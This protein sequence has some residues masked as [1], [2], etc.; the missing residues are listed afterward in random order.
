M[1]LN[2]ASSRRNRENYCCSLVL[3]LTNWISGDGVATA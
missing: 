2:I 1:Q 3:L